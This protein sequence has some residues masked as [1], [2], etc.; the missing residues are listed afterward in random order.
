[1]SAPLPPGTRPQ[2]QEPRKV[3]AAKA[4][5]LAL[6]SYTDDAG[7]LQ[8]QLAIVGDSRVHLLESRSL[9]ISETLTSQGLANK[10]LSEGIFKIL[11][12]KK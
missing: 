3:I 8:T 9:G 4:V 11:N 6:I 5:E 10:W 1:M 2:P 12:G 7:Q